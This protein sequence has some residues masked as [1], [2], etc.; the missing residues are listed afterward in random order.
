MPGFGIIIP[1]LP[2]YAESFGANALIIGLLT[3]SYSITQ[4]FALPV[5]GRLSDQR[6]RRPILIFSILGSVIAWTLFGLASSL[7]FLFIARLIAGAMGG[8]IAAAQAYIADITSEED[9]AAG[10]GLIGAAFGLGF[11]F[12]PGLGALMSYGPTVQFFSDILGFLT[13]NK[14]TLP[15]FTAAALS[16]LNLGMAYA[17]LPETKADFSVKGEMG[18]SALKDALSDSKLRKLI[19]SFFLTSFAFSGME[20]MFL[21]YLQDKFG[22][23]T[24]QGGLLLVYV[25]VLIAIIQGGLIRKLTERYDES[26]LGIA[27]AI[28]GGIGLALIPFAP[29]IGNILWFI[30]GQAILTPGLI[31]LLVILAVYAFGNGVLN[32][33]LNTLVSRSADSSMQGGAFGLTQSAGSLARATGPVIAGGLYTYFAYW[34]PFL[35]GSLLVAAVFYI[36]YTAYF[37]Y[38]EN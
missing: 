18:I 5:L 15:S 30:P 36:L 33:S 29:Q 23:S 12:G 4:F 22:F 11:V 7:I 21:P 19:T 8:N 13:I 16:L 9:R 26:Y 10:L 6:G 32:V 37:V 1:I 28:I 34:S 2:Y 31:A 35:F 3:A 24:T 38:R 14:Y 17:F 20:V 27:G 25:G